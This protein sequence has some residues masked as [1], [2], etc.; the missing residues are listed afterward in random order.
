MAKQAPETVGVATGPSGRGAP[1]WWISKPARPGARALRR[2]RLRTVESGVTSPRRPPRC[3][4]PSAFITRAPTR[5]GGRPVSS[6]AFRAPR[7]PA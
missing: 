4:V 2:V 5:Q 3:S 1:S 6:A 7:Q